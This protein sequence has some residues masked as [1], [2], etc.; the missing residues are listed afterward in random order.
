MDSASIIALG[1]HVFWWIIPIVIVLYILKSSWF[2]GLTGEFF[3][4]LYAKGMLNKDQYQLLKNVILPTED[5][6][7]QID[8][9]IVSVFGVFV[10]ET[11]NMKG[12]IFGNPKDRTWTQKIYK[13]SKKF[14]NPLHQ[15]YKHVKVLEELLGL[16]ESQIFSLVVFMGDSQFKT[17]M[18][19]N[20][21][22]DREYI[23]FIKSKKEEVLS[24]AEVKEIINMIETSRTPRSFEASSEHRHHVQEIKRKKERN[25]TC[26]NC[27]HHMILRKAK[28]GSNKGKQFWG[29]SNFPQCRGT[30][31]IT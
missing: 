11:K 26:P 14:Q 24:L 30:V 2:K 28:K 17:N 25:M 31:N 16:N 5:G 21:A 9:I 6:S 13:F 7:T 22:H 12:W 8:H 29:C 18:P 15:N 1:F 20:V 4:N 23:R 3:V 27:G 10:I 19:E